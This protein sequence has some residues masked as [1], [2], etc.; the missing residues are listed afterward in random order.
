MNVCVFSV[1]VSFCY[2]TNHPQYVWLKIIIIL[3]ST[4][5]CGSAVCVYVCCLFVFYLDEE[6]VEIRDMNMLYKT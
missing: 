6:S 5:S 1:L 3:F 4:Q 2:V